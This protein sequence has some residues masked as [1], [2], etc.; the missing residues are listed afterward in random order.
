MR[1]D[2][3]QKRCIH[4]KNKI[5]KN[6]VPDQIYSRMSLPNTFLPFYS[7]VDS[8]GSCDDANGLSFG[9]DLEAVR[10]GK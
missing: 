2:D 9:L 5:L 10:E 3:F 7:E 6:K 1:S 4:L 8:G